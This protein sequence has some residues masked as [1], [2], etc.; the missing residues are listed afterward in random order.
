M[1]PAILV[2][3]VSTSG[4]DAFPRLIEGNRTFARQQVLRPSRDLS[5]PALVIRGDGI[6]VDF[7]GLILRGSPPD[8]DPDQRKG[9]G[10]QIEGRNIT[11]RNLQVRGYSVG[12]RAV[13]AP[14][15]R[16]ENIDASYNYAARLK[17]TADREDLADWMS[18]HQN[19]KDEWLRYGAAVYLRGCDGA[20]VSGLRVTGGQ[21]G[22][23]VSHTNGGK[24]WNN[25][26]RFNSAIGLGL[27]R[28][29]DN[30]V[31]HNRL[32][33]N[34][35]G[36]STGVY[37]RGQDSSGILIYEQ[38][39]RNVFAYNSVTHSGDGFFLWAGQTTMDTGEGG[40]N[41]NLLYGND[42]SHAP[43][44]GIE[45]TFS[46]NR[47]LNNLVMEC[48]HGVWGGYSYDTVIAGNVF[49]YNDEAI[50]IEHGQDLRI[51][52]NLFF[53]D[54]QAVRL[55]S[56]PTQ[57]PNWGYPKFRDT[58]SRDILIA[59][60]RFLFVANGQNDDGRG[61]QLRAVLSIQ[62]SENVTVR[63]NHLGP[64]GAWLDA[65]GPLKNLVMDRVESKWEETERRVSGD[66]LTTTRTVNEM[67]FGANTYTFPS[68]G[69]AYLG[70]DSEGQLPAAHA[71]T[72]RRGET[73]TPEYRSRFV[74]NW[75][76]LQ[77]QMGRVI[78]VG[79]RDLGAI[80]AWVLEDAPAPLPGGINPFLSEKADRG[81]RTIRMGEWG[82]Y[83]GR[84]P[85]LWPI[86][87]DAG[88]DRFEVL[89]PRGRYRVVSVRGGRVQG[90]GQV[91]GTLTFTPDGSVVDPRIELEYVGAETTDERGRVTPAG[92]PV[93]FGWS[94]LR[95][96][97]KWDVRVWPWT[98]SVN[99][100]D[101]HA[102]PE[103]AALK[104]VWASAPAKQWTVDA[105][106]FATSGGWARD[107]PRDRF[108]TIAEGTIRVPKGRYELSVTADDGIRV[109]VDGKPV[110]DAWKYQGPTPYRAVLDL[111]EGEHRVRIEH[112]EIDGYAALQ[113][114]WRPLP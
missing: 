80:P 41:D 21:N 51:Q 47:F 37:N 114:R 85:L 104:A 36:H 7:G 6:T 44:N 81:W 46:R 38:S 53:R 42:F 25:D 74:H 27:Y 9:L 93:R 88:S 96:P 57:D 56:N 65:K 62:G 70:G 33:Y 89:G 50:A 55:W 11:V 71:L 90:N 98:T 83:D 87:G 84:R 1:L 112:F 43:T 48:W 23:M 106:D 67:T 94:T 60:N 92:K 18:Y 75:D 61:R 72:N 58:R 20:Q 32:D 68:G 109:W 15:L 29:S 66:E 63:N 34:V 8:S 4:G 73:V 103:P 52:G 110:I 78:R 95:V 39:H 13:N 105:L 102:V 5:A 22:L 86:A 2:S 99:P 17:S 26:L 40:C 108:T 64:F 113:V 24:F 76:P 14:G 82:P 91:P 35:R 59:G 30:V 3:V 101:V 31:M 77:P 100:A 79:G 107:L 54:G 97:Q 49:A 45:A 28:S 16:L 69:G 10:V 19:D 111:G 12:I